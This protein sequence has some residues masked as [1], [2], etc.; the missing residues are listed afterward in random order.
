MRGGA[1]KSPRSPI[2]SESNS[3]AKICFRGSRPISEIHLF[4][5]P[6]PHFLRTYPETQLRSAFQRAP[7]ASS[8][9]GC[10]SF[11]SGTAAPGSLYDYLADYECSRFRYE[12]S[13]IVTATCTI[14]PL[15]RELFP[16][17]PAEASL[18]RLNTAPHAA[19]RPPEK[20]QS[21]THKSALLF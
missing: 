6:Y 3:T 17:M 9:N 19:R 11:S 10:R 5:Y 12:P 20:A 4:I 14:T 21:N 16:A 8:R 18:G 15:D 1:Q 13:P 7:G 2:S